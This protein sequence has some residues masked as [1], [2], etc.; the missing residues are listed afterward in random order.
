MWQFEEDGG[1]L[2]EK[3]EMFLE[4]VFAHYS[5]KMSKDSEDKRSKGIPTSHN[6]S[7]ILYGRVIYDDREDAEEERAPLSQA[8]DGTYYRDFF[9][10]SLLSA[11]SSPIS[12]TESHDSMATTGHP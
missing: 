4:E 10:V 9:K 7:V 6:V 3:C 11:R 1:K 2:L 5:G 8:S 12:L